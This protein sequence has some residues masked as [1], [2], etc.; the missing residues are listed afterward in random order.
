MKPGMMRDRVTIE[1]KQVTRNS[2]GDEVVS[3]V[4]VSELWASVEP[5]RGREFF[6]SAQMQGAVDHRVTIWYREGITRDMRVVWRNQPLDIVSVIDVQ[7][8]RRSLELMC[9]M[10]VRNGI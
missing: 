7:G 5:T 6:E 8:L 10:G 1:R 9:V 4:V 3:W 2:I